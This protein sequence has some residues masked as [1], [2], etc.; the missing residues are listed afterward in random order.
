MTLSCTRLKVCEH[1]HCFYFAFSIKKLHHT[2]YIIMKNAH[3]H[4][5]CVILKPRVNTA[6]LLHAVSVI[7][8]MFTF[9]VYK[10][11]VQQH[12]NTLHE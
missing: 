11:S 5:K 10:P 12:K 7:T 1:L 6:E 2:N 9:E 8:E 4:E 3:E